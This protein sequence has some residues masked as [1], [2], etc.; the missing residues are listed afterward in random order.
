[1]V[2]IPV[3]KSVVPLAINTSR[4]K[5]PSHYGRELTKSF[6]TRSKIEN[7]IS[8]TAEGN[9]CEIYI[10]IDSLSLWAQ[11]SHVLAQELIGSTAL[12]PSLNYSPPLYWNEFTAETSTEQRR[13]FF[14]Q[15]NPNLTVDPL[16]STMSHNGYILA[17][18]ARLH[19]VDWSELDEMFWYSLKRL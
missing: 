17:L 16:I 6:A 10:M 5:C 3:A 15:K 12:Q 11:M 13:N 8:Y 18:W 19:L 9:I 7:F 14:S 2:C 4:Q 1:M